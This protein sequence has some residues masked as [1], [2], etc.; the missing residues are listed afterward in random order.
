MFVSV[1][2]CIQVQEFKGVLQ[3]TLFQHTSTAPRQNQDIKHHG[4][5]TRETRKKEKGA[6]LRCQT[7][8]VFLVLYYRV[9]TAVQMCV[10]QTLTV[11]FWAWVETDKCCMRAV[12]PG[13]I[14]GC[15]GVFEGKRYVCMS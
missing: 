12:G 2:K 13:G 8:E 11:N 3:Y 5:K 7:T 1:C 15:L 9:F 14:D 4:R 10:C 6:E